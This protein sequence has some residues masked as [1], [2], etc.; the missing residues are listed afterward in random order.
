[1]LIDY[2]LGQ[3][4]VI[5][6]VKIFDSSVTTGAGLIGLTNSSPGLNISTI[7][8]CEP[9]A[10]AYSVTAGTIDAITTLGL[11]GTITASHCQ[12]KEVDSSNHP[13]IYEL[14]IDNSRFAVSGAK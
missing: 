10:T 12:F 3:T 1:M 11:F 7:A 5:L 14:H 8:D 9:T 13:G 2:Q 4:S 6:R